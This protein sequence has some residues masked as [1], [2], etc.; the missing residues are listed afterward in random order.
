MPHTP[1]SPLN[2]A[3]NEEEN[4][5]Q[6]GKTRRNHRVSRYQETLVQGP[7]NDATSVM[8][9]RNIH[10]ASVLLKMQNVATVTVVVT[11]R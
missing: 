5:S 4:K 9:L 3:S 6:K 1:M 7:N 2:V 11:L 10:A 8:R